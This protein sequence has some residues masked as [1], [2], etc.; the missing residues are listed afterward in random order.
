MAS[1]NLDEHI[2]RKGTNASKWEGMKKIS[3]LANDQTLPF[4]VAD[5][6]FACPP[7]VI[8]ALHQKIED[9]IFG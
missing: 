4:W 7:A 6:D 1:Y 5:M 2:E 3:P 8:E 9:R